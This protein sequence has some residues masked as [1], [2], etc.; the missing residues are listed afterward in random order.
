MLKEKNWSKELELDIV[1]KW[2]E[3]GDYAFADNGKQLYSIDTPPPYVNTPVHIGHATTYTLMDMFARFRRMT[4]FNVLFPLGLDRNGLPIELAAEKRFGVTL[5]DVRREEFLKMCRQVLEESSEASIDSFLR[6]GISFNSWSV[7]PKAGDAY[8][9]DS[10]EYR[11]LTQSTFID[12]W[13]KGLIYE[14]KRLN[15]YCPGCKTTLADDEV[16][17][18]EV[19][20]SLNHI[21]LKIKET[22]KE[23]VIATTRPEL[24]CTAAIV[25]FNPEDSRHQH[26]SNKTAVIPF[27]NIEVPVKSHPFADPAFGTGLVF[28]SRSAGDQ[29]AIRFL[30]EE[31]IEPLSAINTEGRMDGVSG[32]LKGMKSDEARKEMIRR[33]KEEGLLVKQ[34]QIM[35]NVPICE[36]SK[37]VIEYITMPEFY[38]KQTEYKDEIRRI[39]YEINFFSPKSRQILLDWIDSVS[40]DWAI[41]RRRY[42]ATEIPLWYCKKCNETIVPPKG[43]Y[44]Q[45]W[46]EPPPDSMTPEGR[47]VPFKCPSC[48]SA[49]FRGE[50]RVLDTWF[51]SSISPLYV[52]HYPEEFFHKHPVCTLR[53]QGKEIIRNWLYY[54]LLRCFHATGRSIFR[55]VWIHYHVVDESGKKMSKSVGNIIDP[56]EIL[57]RYSAEPFR[58]WAAIEGNITSDDFRCSFERIEGAG[59]TITKLWNVARFVSLFERPAEKPELA[60]TDR[61][62]MQEMN[63]LIGFSR[64]SYEN[65]DFHN[66]AARIKHFIWETFAS[67]YIELVKSRAYNSAGVFTKEQQQSA[68][69]TLHYCLDTLLKLLAPVIPMI[70]YRIYMDLRGKNIHKENFPET[71]E[72]YKIPFST[73]ELEQL[74]SAI[75]KAKKD[76]SLSLKAPVKLLALD[77]KFRV[78]EHDLKAAHSVQKIEYGKFAVEL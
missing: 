62:I 55:D 41:S 34:E 18:K 63:E 54:T 75:W 46:R 39:A 40:I 8:Y 23:I 45:P 36:R 56:H 74:N 17:H 53:P 13:H 51:D 2:K 28:M 65:Y 43:K 10:P 42:Y 11:A 15:N 76:A 66:P 57:E 24:L 35:H 47:R 21:V 16:D 71:D 12:L 4:G 37:H 59:K 26:L 78:I 52:L 29:D 5:T 30:R 64:S 73:A 1:K 72:E 69:Y 61:W 33:L 20:T 70:T 27:Y 14:D 19:P 25:I 9:T 77:E 7:G 50:E 22:G 58:F 68:L 60:E 44:Y 49:E 32:F 6:L 3:D 48:G 31:G 67:H 38:L